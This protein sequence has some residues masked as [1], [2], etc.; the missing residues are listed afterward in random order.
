MNGRLLLIAAVAIGAALY[1]RAD[2]PD[3]SQLDAAGSESAPIHDVGVSNAAGRSGAYY[4]PLG[5]SPVDVPVLVLMHP[6]GSSGRAFI[7]A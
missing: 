4:A 7:P 1:L 6:T 2:G 5:L 3:G